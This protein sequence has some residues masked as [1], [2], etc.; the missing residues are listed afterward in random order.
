[1]NASLKQSLAALLAG[2]LL[3][4]FPA[5]AGESMPNTVKDI[6]V[7]FG[8]EASAAEALILRNIADAKVSINVAAYA[9]SSPVIVDAL[10]AA[11]KRGVDVRLV[12]DRK[13]NIED[14][15]KGI[16]RKAL[17]ALVAAGASV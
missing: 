1:M 7:A 3:Q 5:K 14:D 10:A 17:D 16:G 12:V 8:P 11:R 4:A 6:E 15:P 2:C 9:F 13:H